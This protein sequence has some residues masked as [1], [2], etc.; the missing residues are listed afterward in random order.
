MIYQMT[1]GK[2]YD[3]KNAMICKA[4]GERYKSQDKV[5]PKCGSSNCSKIKQTTSSLNK[6]I[7]K[8][9]EK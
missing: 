7:I 4:C 2:K 5:C 9:K 1:T 8:T 3:D 6:I